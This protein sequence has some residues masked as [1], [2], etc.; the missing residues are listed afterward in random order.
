M[1]FVYIIIQSDTNV[2]E[3]VFDMV[4]KCYGYLLM[5][6]FTIAIFKI[7]INKCK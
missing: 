7:V 5:Y 2:F 6:M 4:C 1:L 3:F